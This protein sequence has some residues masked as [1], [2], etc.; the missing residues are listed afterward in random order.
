MHK[1]VFIC[2]CNECCR[3]VSILA[4]GL[5]SVCVCVCMCVYS[6]LFS[7]VVLQ[8][9]KFYKWP[10]NLNLLELLWKVG[11]CVIL[12]EFGVSIIR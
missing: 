10:D 12:A 5:T 9:S 6:R 7:L 3:C 1:C 2:Y 8:A 11:L 4:L